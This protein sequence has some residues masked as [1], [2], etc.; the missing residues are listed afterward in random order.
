[1]PYV[2]VDV[3]EV[4][5][6][7]RRVG[8]VAL[9]PASGYYV[10]EYSPE[11]RH[12]GIELAPTTMPT[13]TAAYVFTTLPP[14]TFHRLPA[15]LADALPDDFGNALTTAYLVNEGVSA[16]TITPL[17]RLA[18]LASR[19]TGALEFRPA[20]GPRPRKSTAVE[21]SELVLAA[22]T[23][24]AGT[25]GA[26]DGITDAVKHLIAVGTSAGG[27]RAKAVI[28]WNPT[29]DEVR[30]GQLSADPGFE[31]W[32]LKLDGVGADTDLGQS[33]DFGR[34]EYAYSLMAVAA[35]VS[36]SECRLL[37]EGG[38]SHFMTRR[39]DRAA[40]GTKIHMQTLCALG[41]LDFRLIGAHDY[42]QLFDM[43]SR[44]GLGPETRAEVYRRMVFNVAA[45]NCDDH[46]K[47]F[48]FVLAEDGEWELSPA[49]DVTHAHNPRSRW[50]AQHLMSVNGRF[51]GIDRHDLVEVA[52]RFAVPSPRGIVLDVLDSVDRWPE[53]AREAHVSANANA[54]VAANISTMTA[55]LR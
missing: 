13:N 3:I 45:A 37:H 18:Y 38:R 55:S 21:L 16:S 27:A 30:S 42:A 19:G 11:W 44:L 12:G 52:D 26:E 22:R 39:F 4:L 47:N 46:T 31:Q 5:A 25:F 54:E 6:W 9:D 35:G 20:R 14:E 33:A 2:P 50:T 40:D 1:M 32:L 8:A 29:T 34:I 28:A 17:D 7:G 48:S 53:F 36:M 49:Y 24:A 43:L 23:E 51:T 10:F 15:M 41:H